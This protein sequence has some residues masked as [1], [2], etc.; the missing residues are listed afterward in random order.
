MYAGRIER[1]APAAGRS[2]QGGRLWLLLAGIG[3]AA[4]APGITWYFIWPGK[5]RTS[6]AG[7]SAASIAVLPFLNVSSDPGQD[8]FSDGIT[9]EI[10]S[11][12]SRLRGLSVAARTSVARFKS[13]SASPSEIGSA[14]GV[15]WLLEGSV[16]RAGDHIR[17]TTTL[18]K[19]ADDFHL[20]DRLDAAIAHFER[21]LAIDPGFAPVLAQAGEKDRAR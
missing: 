21:A 3:V 6:A 9:E 12:L 20:R 11:K 16:R 17:V 13:A 5:L 1:T 7:P 14:L 4:A 8:Y 10:I 19:S 2:L 15:A 18:L